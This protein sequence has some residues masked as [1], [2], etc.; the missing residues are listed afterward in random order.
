MVSRRVRL[1][2]KNEQGAIWYAQERYPLPFTADDLMIR[3]PWLTHRGA[4]RILNSLSSPGRNFLC[5]NGFSYF[6]KKAGLR[7]P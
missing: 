1:L 2:T 7:V 4:V 3:M 6:W 5:G